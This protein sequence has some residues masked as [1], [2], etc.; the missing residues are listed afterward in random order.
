V[1]MDYQ[2]SDTYGVRAVIPRPKLQRAN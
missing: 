1:K 2:R